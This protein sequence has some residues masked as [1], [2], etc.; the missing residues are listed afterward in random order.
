V[1]RSPVPFA[2][3]ASVALSLA[4][5]SAAGPSAAQV[6]GLYRVHG[7]MRVSAA[8]LLDRATE[9]HADVTLEPGG[10]PRD[11]RVRLASEGYACDLVGR[12]AEDGALDFSAGQRCALDMRP[13]Q[14]R[15]RVEATLRAARGRVRDDQLE[16]ELTADLSGTVSVRTGG[17]VQVL[18]TPVDLP[19]GWTPETPVRGQ[20][21][22]TVQGGRDHSRTS[23]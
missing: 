1:K 10:G 14:A 4:G 8:P 16:L 3:T 11:V 19:E 21:H 13:P 18:G 20:A 12:L 7:T 22:G 23:P 2:L 9:A 15:G 17:R 5:A 6:R